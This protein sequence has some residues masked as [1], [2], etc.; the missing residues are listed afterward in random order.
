MKELCDRTGLP[1]QAIHF[2]IQQGLLPAGRKTG[3]NTAVYGEAHVDRLKLIKKLQHERFLP[4]KAI[5]ALLEEQDHAFTPSQLVAL[6]GVKQRL[7]FL[8]SKQNQRGVHVDALVDRLGIERAEVERVVELGVLGAR[9]EDGQMLIAEDDVWILHAWAEM[10]RQGL[11][12]E[13]RLS[14]DDVLLI[15]EVVQELFNR[16]VALVA[17]RL[18]HIAPER[19]A[20][21]I[22]KGLPIVH[23]LLVGFH[24]KKL[25]NFFASL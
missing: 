3:R 22:E 17:G 5:K 14:V 21:L 10:K 12:D 19:A 4:L 18:A 2:Y 23:S 8:N 15:Q 13:L 6:T 24:T 9:Y 7:R 25:R 16:E 1:R 20:D 11:V